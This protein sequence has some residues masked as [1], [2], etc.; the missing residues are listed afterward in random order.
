MAKTITKDDAIAHKKKAIRSI[1]N[2]FEAFINSP[3]SKHLKKADLR[4]K[5]M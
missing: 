5:V 1:G 2:V 4:F 3:D